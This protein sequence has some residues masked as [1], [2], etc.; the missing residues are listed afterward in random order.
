MYAY[1]LSTFTG[2]RA[3]TAISVNPRTAHSDGG[4]RGAGTRLADLL[5]LGACKDTVVVVWR[6]YGGIPLGNVRWKLITEVAR[7]A[8]ERAGLWHHGGKQGGHNT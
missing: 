2:A 7:E 5:E 1:R 4:E 8:L 6:W 3:T